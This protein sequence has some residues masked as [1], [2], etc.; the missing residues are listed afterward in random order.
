MKVICEDGKGS[1]NKAA[2]K[3]NALAVS[4]ACEALKANLRGDCYSVLSDVTQATTDDDYFYL[5]NDS[6]RDL[7]IY[8]IEGWY[9]DAKEEISVYIGGTADAAAG[10][11]LTPINMNTGSG[12][13]AGVTCVQH[14]ADLAIAGGSVGALLKFSET[15]LELGTFDFPAGIILT[16]GSRLHMEASLDGVSNTNVYFYFREA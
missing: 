13:A 5:K 3:N 2:V 9:A 14:T 1:G 16:P 7:V 8:K 12:N 15:A 4:T 10:S 6:N 11:A